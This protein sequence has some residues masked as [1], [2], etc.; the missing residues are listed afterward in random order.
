M[1]RTVTALAALAALA[2][3]FGGAPAKA[4]DEFG[5]PELVAAAKAELGAQMDGTPM[6]A[7]ATAHPA[8][9]A[10]AV[11][12]ATGIRPAA[13]LGKP[14]PGMLRGILHRHQLRPDEL[15]MV[16]DR[17]YTDM[18]MARNAGALGVLVLT[19]ETTAEAA[20]LSTQPDLVVVDLEE[21]G[22]MLRKARPGGVSA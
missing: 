12:R 1:S 2:L 6:V 16:G 15:A 17:L 18:A 10:D 20:R 13:V 5:S 3:A 8:K 4:A 9:F 22:V 7:L 19:G 21:L 14:D 11:E